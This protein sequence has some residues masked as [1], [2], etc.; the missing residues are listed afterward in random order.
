MVAAAYSLVATS[1]DTLRSA[2]EWYVA[3]GTENLTEA[4]ATRVRRTASW[5]LVLSVLLPVIILAQIFRPQHATALV[6]TCF[7]LVVAALWEWALRRPRERAMLAQHLIMG[8]TVL[9]LVVTALLNGGVNGSGLWYLSLIPLLVAPQGSARETALWTVVAALAVCLVAAVDPHWWFK[10]DLAVEPPDLVVMMRLLLLAALCGFAITSVKVMDRYVATIEESEQRLALQTRQLALAKNETDA[11]RVVLQRHL[12]ALLHVSLAAANERSPASLVRSALDKIVRILG[13]Q[14]AFLLLCRPDGED[15]ELFAGRD[16]DRR[17]FDTI[18]PRVQTLAAKTSARRLPLMMGKGEI[19]EAA[20]R[21][22]AAGTYNSLAVPLLLRE[23]LLGVI[24]V[25]DFASPESTFT[26][27]DAEILLAVGNHV[28][29]G[30]EAARAAADRDDAERRLRESDERFRQFL[31]QAA[32]AL[33]VADEG[34]RIVEANRE[35]CGLLGYTR[36][37]ILELSVY[38]ID[39]DLSEDEA[40]RLLAGISHKGHLAVERR[41]KRKDGSVFPVE[42]RVS[43]I[44]VRDD[45]HFLMAARDI[46]ERKHAAQ[47]LEQSRTQLRAL[48]SRLLA[49]QEEERKHLAR[50]VHDELGQALTALSLDVGWLAAHVKDDAAATEQVNKIG[51]LLET[52][53]GSVQR[54]ARELRPLLLD[55]LGLIPA[56]EWMAREFQQRTRIPCVLTAPSRGIVL[57]RELDTIVFRLVQEALTNVARH[58]GAS[59]VRISLQ[60]GRGEVLL[61]VEDDGRGIRQEE[62]DHHD[63]LGLLGMRERVRMCDGT[64]HIQGAEGR[65]TQL[66]FTIPAAPRRRELRGEV[67]T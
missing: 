22:T 1:L 8:A 40:A 36:E 46:T 61:T 4:E 24:C 10:R 21:S 32:D 17:D 13:A 20:P 49:V 37:E 44:N 47:Q 62:I 56:L 27:A 64:M 9:D 15:L 42:L 55:D 19:A 45:E 60:R 58:A 52:T 2:A 25:D 35:A 7:G 50:E 51:D 5:I 14:H 43:R 57:D 3:R 63:S 39:P 12:D 31:A 66:K 54:I 41:L 18:D 16:G 67:R 29:I 65:G 26:V 23:R 33:Y 53:I 38:D 48:S 30:L 34:G 6:N 59:V 11:A 28:A